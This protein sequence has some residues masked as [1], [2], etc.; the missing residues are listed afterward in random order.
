MGTERG[1]GRLLLDM[2]GVLIVPRNSEIQL[3]LLRQTVS[4]DFYEKATK[5][6]SVMRRGSYEDY[7]GELYGKGN[8][9]K[10]IVLD[11]D[12]SWRVL[13]AWD[14]RELEGK[15]ISWV[16][17]TAEM[18]GSS[19]RD[20][21]WLPRPGTKIELEDFD[22]NLVHIDN[23]KKQRSNK[24]IVSGNSYWQRREIVNKLGKGMTE[25]LDP[26]FGVVL[27]PHYGVGSGLLKIGTDIW[28]KEGQGEKVEAEDDDYAIA[29]LHTVAGIRVRM[30]VSENDAKNQPHVEDIIIKSGVAHLIKED[31]VEFSK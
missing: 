4:L 7:A 21:K 17:K 27:P 14:I 6:A 29:L 31:M 8:L 3:P 2:T 19:L 15:E 22:P 26:T 5:L 10:R 9:F 18:M 16:E 11:Q 1:K 25:Q 24:S 23:L 12:L 28:F 13:R 30:P 20:P